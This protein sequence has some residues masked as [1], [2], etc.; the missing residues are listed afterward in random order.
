MSRGAGAVA[1]TCSSSFNWIDEP[2][3]HLMFESTGLVEIPTNIFSCLFFVF[4]NVVT[5]SQEHSPSS[6]FP[7]FEELLKKKKKVTKLI[8]RKA[9]KIKF[10]FR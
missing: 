7:V 5:N 3:E 4:M 2:V 8:G 1:F 10:Y 9:F 6:S